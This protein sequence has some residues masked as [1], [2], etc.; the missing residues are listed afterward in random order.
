MHRL[1]EQLQNVAASIAIF[2]TYFG[3]KVR[4]NQQYMLLLIIIFFLFLQGQLGYLLPWLLYGCLYLILSFIQHVVFAVTNFNHGHVAVG[5]GFV[6]VLIIHE[7][8]L[9]A[10]ED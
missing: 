9:S 10:L 1:E 7:C 5:V 2:L 3:M 8:K 6:V 4:Q